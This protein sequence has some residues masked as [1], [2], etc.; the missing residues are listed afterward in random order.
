MSEII[1]IYI[2]E[3]EGFLKEKEGLGIKL[4]YKEYVHNANKYPKQTARFKKLG[5]YIESENEYKQF[6]LSEYYLQSNRENNVYRGLY[7]LIEK[8]NTLIENQSTIIENQGKQQIKLL[9]RILDKLGRM[10]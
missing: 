1:H 6:L 5:C 4:D 2:N 7:R 8:Q 10:S 9:E 3:F